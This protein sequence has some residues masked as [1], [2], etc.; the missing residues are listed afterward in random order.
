[1]KKLFIFSILSGLVLAHY[2]IFLSRPLTKSSIDIKKD[3]SFL[4]I[5]WQLSGYDKKIYF[6]LTALITG[7]WSNLQHG[8]YLGTYKPLEIIKQMEKGIQ[9]HYP[10]TI[11]PGMRNRDIVQYLTSQH[12]LI[13]DLQNF[14]EGS[15][16]ADTYYVNYQD[17]M[18]KIIAQAQQKMQQYLNKN[19]QYNQNSQLKNHKQWLIFA[20]LLEKE[21]SKIDDQKMIAGVLVN[22]LK[23]N[24]S[25][26]LDATVLY[27][28]PEEKINTAKS[29]Q[30]SFNTYRVKGLP[31]TPIAIP[32]K[33]ALQA[34]LKPAEHNYFY[35]LAD[36][37]GKHFFSKT[38]QQHQ[39]MIEKHLK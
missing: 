22:R 34:S 3:Q 33:N 4:S 25:L 36:K 37:N 10:I 2:L 32:G 24:M 8:R 14:T 35:Y 12:Y 7:S 18:N 19:W 13:D 16:W 30:N 20:S 15:L 39:V 9:V 21:A 28:A 26:D 1:M 29:T 27:F 38:Y 31:P 6:A 23:K 17:S 5:A 11:V